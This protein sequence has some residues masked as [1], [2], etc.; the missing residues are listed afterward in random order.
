[1]FEADCADC[2]PSLKYACETLVMSRRVAASTLTANV[3]RSDALRAT[4]AGAG[5]AMA[6]ST[7]DASSLP[8]PL[9]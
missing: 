6:T 1:M 9:R 2:A 4:T 8:A 7:A 5:S 3:M